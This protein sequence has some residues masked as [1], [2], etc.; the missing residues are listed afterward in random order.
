MAPGNAK[1]SEIP[2]AKNIFIFYKQKPA[3]KSTNN[4]TEKNVK[5]TRAT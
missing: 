4:K 1:S 5:Y 2:T 3:K